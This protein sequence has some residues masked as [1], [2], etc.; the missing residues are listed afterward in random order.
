MKTVVIEKERTRDHT[1]DMIRQFGGTI[2]VTG[3][4][5]HVQGPQ[6]LTG[7][8]VVVPG[9]ISSAAFFLVAGLI[10]P[11]S[12]IVLENVGLNPTRTGNY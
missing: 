10:L 7:Q 5:I 8:E 2:E 12:K 9:D 1:E 4:E 3:K 11:E 6:R